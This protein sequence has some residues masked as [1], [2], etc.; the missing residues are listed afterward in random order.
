M[1]PL[2]WF[3]PVFSGQVR[4]SVPPGYRLHVVPCVAGVDPKHKRCV[5]EAAKWKGEDGR[6]LP[7][8][9]RALGLDVAARPFL[10]AFSAGGQCVRRLLLDPRDRAEIGGVYMADATY[11]AWAQPGIVAVDELQDA[12]VSFAV[13]CAADGRPLVM[14]ASSHVPG[15]GGPSASATL[16]ALAYEIE[17]RAEGAFCKVAPGDPVLAGL[18][19]PVY[20]MRLGSVLYVDFGREV[21]HAGHAT[22][23]APALLPR[24]CSRA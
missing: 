20:A 2:V 19:S 14:T 5:D 12:L 6:R 1:I 3:G 9:R 10:A 15:G 17:A 13:E 24:V 11:A 21:A 18:G 23:I 22:T 16:Q 7:G 4:G 8:L